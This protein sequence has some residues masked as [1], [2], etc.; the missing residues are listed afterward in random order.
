MIILSLA[1]SLVAC[2]PKVIDSEPPDGVDSDS[3]SDTA[4]GPT[5]VATAEPTVGVVPFEVVLSGLG[6]SAGGSA[7]EGYEWTLPDGAVVAGE[8]VTTTMLAEGD[9]SFSLT[10]VDQGGHSSEMTVEV[11]ASCPG[12]AE[13]TVAGA[14]GWGE[15]S[16]LA[17]ASTA[18]VLWGH[19]DAQGRGPE[20]FAISTDA[21]L[22]GTFLLAGVSD[23]D[24]EDIARG[25]GPEEGVSYLYV[26]DTGDNSEARSSVTVYRFPEPLD[27]DGGA[28]MGAE[29]IT[30]TY[31]DGPRDAETLLIDPLTGDLILVER[32]RDDRGESGI[33]V[34]QAPLS[35]TGP[36]ALTQMGSLTFGTDPLPGDVDATGGDVSPDGQI[37]AIRTHDR[38]WAFARDPSLP[39]HTAFAS[40][41]CGTPEVFDAKG[42]AIA[43]AWD[44]SGYYT[45]SEGVG[46]PLYWYGSQ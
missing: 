38:V 3:P 36:T 30:L 42:E 34:A 24:W 8:T 14:M 23:V 6:S 35:T 37:V 13:A 12:F 26:G 45:A 41:A 27:F 43:L 33:F 16:G 15:V 5:A 7:I 22:L 1:L 17:A 29:A 4:A 9:H 46:E 18:G 28:I 11:L 10:V 39:L 2:S 21:R 32:D 44:G 40:P 19:S 31:P 25:P 20:V